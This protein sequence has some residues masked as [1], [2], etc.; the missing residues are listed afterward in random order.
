MEL[1][2]GS[3]NS[4]FS[5]RKIDG[6]HDIK[7]R[8]PLNGKY[9]LLGPGQHFPGDAPEVIINSVP[10]STQVSIRVNVN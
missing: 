3:L 9:Y 2:S 7:S 6:F 8:S 4:G 5:I 1:N 10:T